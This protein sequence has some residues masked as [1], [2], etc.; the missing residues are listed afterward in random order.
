MEQEGEDRR[1]FSEVHC[2]LQR[3][4]HYGFRSWKR[5]TSE[6]GMYS[7]LEIGF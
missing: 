1:H 2:E 4:N 7:L 5:V 6:T 3:T